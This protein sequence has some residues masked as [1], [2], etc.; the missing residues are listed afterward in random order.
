MPRL[1]ALLALFSLL[2]PAAV[3]AER[4][5]RPPV[6]AAY[7]VWYSTGT[8]P[9]QKWVHWGEPDKPT[10]A[11]RPLIGPYD[12]DDRNVVRWHVRVAKAAG[13][14]GFFVSWWGPGRTD[15]AFAKAVLPIAEEEGFKVA[16][17]DETAQF[18]RDWPDVKQ[19]LAASLAKYKDSPAYLKIDGEPVCYLYQVAADPRL[20]PQTF[21]ELA[22]FVEAK[23]GPVYW[24]VDKIANPDNHFQI[25]R[26]WLADPRPASAYAFYATF[27][28]FR[29][30]DYDSLLA[31]YKPVVAA[32]HDA[33]LKMMVPV[34]PGHDNR[35]TGNKDAF[36]IPRDD[37]ATLRGYFRAATDSGADL[38]LL[39]SWN[40]WP[41]TTVVEP[42]S[43]WDDPYRY[44]KIVAEF[45]GLEFRKPPEPSSAPT[46]TPARSPDRTSARSPRG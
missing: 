21:R 29:T 8:G 27:S 16:L 32:A 20:T 41:E 10:S 45:N 46:R 22:E 4:P 13:L 28:I 44:L 12:S 31:R 19:R 33:G 2:Y 15:S 40:E 37:G 9:H 39:T 18:Q 42:S 26:A 24:I 3:R 30:W 11:A 1:L 6:Y 38:I 23:V 35:G 25:P 14:S 5:A 34:H 36:V 7:Y 43:S 17:M